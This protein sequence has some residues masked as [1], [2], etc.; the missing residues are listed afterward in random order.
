MDLYIT[1]DSNKKYIFHG[2]YKDKQWPKDHGFYWDPDNI[3]WYTYEKYLAQRLLKCLQHP[4]DCNHLKQ[5][6]KQEIK[7]VEQ[8]ENN[9]QYPSPF[10][11]PSNWIDTLWEKVAEL[12]VKEDTKIKQ[13]K[14]FNQEKLNR[15]QKDLKI[16]ARK[17]KIS[18]D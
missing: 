11:S 15:Q 18:F 2:G 16:T 6:V 14:E 10:N 3:H 13:Q 7:Q 17:R 8:I 5:P 4:L 9:T 12:K 1:K